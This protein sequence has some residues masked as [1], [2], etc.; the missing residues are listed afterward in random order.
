MGTFSRI[1]IGSIGIAATA[2]GVILIYRHYND[3]QKVKKIKAQHTKR[4]ESPAKSSSPSFTTCPGN[5]DKSEAS[6]SPEEIQHLV[7]ML[8]AANTTKFL[9]IM[10]TLIQFSN[11]NVNIVR[12]LYVL[13]FS[14]PSVHTI[15]WTVCIL[16]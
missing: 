15:F 12:I 8:P 9:K 6:I 10:K 4:D 13:L 3:I 1:A 5:N 16:N 11:D 14:L 7:S 2:F